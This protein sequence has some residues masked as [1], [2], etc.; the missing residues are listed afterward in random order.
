[1]NQNNCNSNWKKI[2]GFR[3]MQEKLEKKVACMTINPSCSVCLS[4]MYNVI[5][6]F[7]K[8]H[9]SVYILPQIHRIF[10]KILLLNITNIQKY[11]VLGEFKYDFI[12]VWNPYC[13]SFFLSKRSKAAVGGQ[14][15][16]DLFT[17]FFTCQKKYYIQGIPVT[18]YSRK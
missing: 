7:M 1:M 5:R 10:L 8:S 13:V 4:C 16:P 15:H 11:L 9:L 3:N 2:F 17:L 12:K 14:I 6:D 18:A